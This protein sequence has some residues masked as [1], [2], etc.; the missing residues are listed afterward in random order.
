[1]LS[2]YYDRIGRRISIEEWSRLLADHDYKF[3]AFDA[4]RRYRVSTVWIGADKSTDGVPRIFQSVVFRGDKTEV[5]SALYSTEDEARDGHQAL[6][7]NY[8]PAVEVL[9]E[10]ADADPDESR[11]T[12]SPARRAG[13]EARRRRKR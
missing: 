1:M 8:V 2:R 10:L 6:A 9:A 11:E 4:G 3:V 13:K 7:T 5:E 12:M